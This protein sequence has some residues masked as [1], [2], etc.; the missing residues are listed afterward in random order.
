MGKPTT[1]KSNQDM[2]AAFAKASGDTTDPQKLATVAQ[3]GANL[4]TLQGRNSG[5]ARAARTL[6]DGRHSASGQVLTGYAAAGQEVTAEMRAAIDELDNLAIHGN[7][8]AGMDDRVRMGWVGE[9]ASTY[10]IGMLERREGELVKQLADMSRGVL[11][12][13]ARLTLRAKRASTDIIEHEA[14]VLAADVDP[15]VKANWDNILGEMD[16]KSITTMLESGE[17]QGIPRNYAVAYQQTL[18]QNRATTQTHTLQGGAAVESFRAS[19]IAQNYSDPR[20]LAKQIEDHNR[21][22]QLLL[23]AGQAPKREIDLGEGIGVVPNGDAVNALSMLAELTEDG[24]LVGAQFGEERDAGTSLLLSELQQG[25]NNSITSYY[26]TLGGVGVDVDSSSV[27]T[28]G[29]QAAMTRLTVALAQGDVAE[30]VK[31]NENIQN[32]I[33]SSRTAF[34][35]G[36]T[37]PQLKAAYSSLFNLRKF[38]SSEQAVDY[39]IHTS[40]DQQAVEVTGAFK[41]MNTVITALSGA[42]FER[43]RDLYVDTTGRDTAQGGE[44]P[45]P[46]GQLFAN[47]PTAKAS[48]IQSWSAQLNADLVQSG[49]KAYYANLGQEVSER[50]DLDDKMKAVILARIQDMHDEI[51]DARGGGQIT[52]HAGVGLLGRAD[53]RVADQEDP[54][55]LAGVALED[56]AGNV[57]QVKQLNL[58]AITQRSNVH[59]TELMEL[60]I[61]ADKASPLGFVFSN[62]D[63]FIAQVV[64]K[65][66][67]Q[68]G[69]DKALFSM[70]NDNYARNLGDPEGRAVIAA[71]LKAGA[72][73]MSAQVNDSFANEEFQQLDSSLALAVASDIANSETYQEAFERWTYDNKVDQLLERDD[74]FLR[75]RGLSREQLSRE[76]AGITAQG[77]ERIGG[78]GI[79]EQLGG[80][81][82]TPQQLVDEGYLTG[83]AI[84]SFNRG[85]Q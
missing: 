69:T 46:L 29:V 57:V 33:A 6:V 21:E 51:F 45:H 65:N 18:I 36:V 2:F 77:D 78:L 75:E 40:T 84:Q 13:D 68:S 38:N 73:V 63:Q 7:A 28:S 53:F 50:G 56:R 9:G 81:R 31:A 66:I 15:E 35:D 26:A 23:E 39:L 74:M 34:L 27:L 11:T 41:E 76:A 14:K 47:D 1:I 20:I 52:G 54:S 55:N 83:Q 17:T 19:A 22:N 85:N 5:S 64:E 10:D 70:I 42:E 43:N 48:A 59:Q 8:I 12:E 61:G 32:E 58:S 79:T 67:P 4:G 24:I 80:N 30:A 3:F 25:A 82:P 62:A 49:L 44:V 71:T 72:E 60:G 16:V 37:E